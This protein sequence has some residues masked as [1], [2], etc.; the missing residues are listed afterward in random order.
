MQYG[1]KKLGGR[2]G[3][4]GGGLKQNFSLMKERGK[5]YLRRGASLKERAY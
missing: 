1:S 4:G 3:G 2:M 5:A